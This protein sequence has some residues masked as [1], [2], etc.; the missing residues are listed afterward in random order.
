MDFEEL[1][2]YQVDR[3]MAKS[4]HKGRNGKRIPI[5]QVHYTGYGPEADTWEPRQNLKNAPVV[6]KEW[7]DNKVS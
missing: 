3:I 7:I 4:W 1:P 2:E 6:L 5:Y